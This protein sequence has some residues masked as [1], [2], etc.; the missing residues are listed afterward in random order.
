MKVFGDFGFSSFLSIFWT[1]T[2]N[3]DIHTRIYLSNHEILTFSLM[4]LMDGSSVRTSSLMIIVSNEITL[5]F[6]AGCNSLSVNSWLVFFF[7][8]FLSWLYFHSIINVLVSFAW[9]F[10]NSSIV[11][12]YGWQTDCC[13]CCYFPLYFLRIHL[14]LSHSN[15]SF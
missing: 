14:F 2:T 3:L 6:T 13:C 9:L 4:N 15:R 5:P 7:N 11:V 8:F 12:D 10:D 1:D